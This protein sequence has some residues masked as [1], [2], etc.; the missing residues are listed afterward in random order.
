MMMVTVG[1][2]F[3]QG[4]YIVAEKKSSGS[5]SRFLKI[6]IARFFGHLCLQ[7][8]SVYLINFS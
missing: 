4:E 8:V 6:A 3:R 1:F 5:G 7:E 2:L